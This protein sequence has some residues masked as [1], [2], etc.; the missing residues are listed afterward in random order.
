MI[1]D[2]LLEELM[3]ELCYYHSQD[4]ENMENKIWE[5]IKFLSGV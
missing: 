3:E 5:E 2:L 4:D 1:P